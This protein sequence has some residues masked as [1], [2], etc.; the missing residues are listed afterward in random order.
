MLRIVEACIHMC[1]CWVLCCGAFYL[2]L[3]RRHHQSGPT[4][5]RLHTAHTRHHH[6][7]GHFNYWHNFGE[8]IGR[9]HPATTT[10]TL[11]CIVSSTY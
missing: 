2:P 5:S 8:E 3:T 6:H 4:D 10:Q 1:G 11:Y 9:H 7:Q